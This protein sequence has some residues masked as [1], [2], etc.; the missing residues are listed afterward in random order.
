VGS[1][2]QSRSHDPSGSEGGPFDLNWQYASHNLRENFGLVRN[3]YGAGLVT[4]D[5]A[6]SRVMELTVDEYLAELD[7][8][9]GRSRM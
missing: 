5:T 6:F 9:A 2:S 8:I 1:D 7:S 3:L 4:G